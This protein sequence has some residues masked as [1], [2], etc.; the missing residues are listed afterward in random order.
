MAIPQQLID[1]TPDFL[2]WCVASEDSIRVIKNTRGRYFQGSVNKMD[3]SEYTK[4][5]DV[6]DGVDEQGNAVIRKVLQPADTFRDFLG[7]RPAHS[8]LPGNTIDLRVN[9]YEAP[10]GEGW[11][12]SA[13]VEMGGKRYAMQ[14]DG[15][16]P[17]DMGRAWQEV[18]V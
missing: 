15:D 13:V 10:G 1:K 8:F 6:P 4:V 11:F 12:I 18:G 16:G 3:E 17:S 5:V 2:A 7:G 14:Y 9:R